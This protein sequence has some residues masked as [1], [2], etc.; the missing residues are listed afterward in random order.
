[1]AKVDRSHI[2]KAGEVMRL[3]EHYNKEPARLRKEPA[4]AKLERI[5][6]DIAK[7]LPPDLD[8][9]ASLDKLNTSPFSVSMD[10]VNPTLIQFP[11]AT[12]RPNSGSSRLS[13]N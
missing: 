10:F 11:A 3:A 7:S 5:N 6:G 1:M 9:Q 8:H 13:V 4:R 12:R 2:R